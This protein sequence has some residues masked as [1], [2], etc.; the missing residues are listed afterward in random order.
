MKHVLIVG[1]NS[2]IGASF[3]KYAGERCSIQ[4][5]SAR[6]GK[7]RD[8]NFTG[9]DSILY[10]AGIAHAAQNK[11]MKQL[12]YHV[13]CD[14]AV[15]VAEHAKSAGVKQFIYLSSMSVYGNVGP[16]IIPETQP[17]AI[18]FYGGSKLAAEEK[19]QQL[20]LHVCIL[21]PPMV[22]GFGCKGNFPR[23]V[24]LSKSMLVFPKIKNRRSMIYIDNLCEFV[25]QA[26]M[27]NKSGIHFPQNAEYVNTTELVQII[28]RLHGKEIRATGLLNPMIA[29][30]KNCLS[31]MDKL[32]GD[33]VYEKTG[34]EANYNVISFEDGVKM[35][36]LGR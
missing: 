12:Y 5:V 33:L 1:E 4:T 30:L 9:I 24:K 32:F 19:L 35:A 22:Y 3:A 26:I 28:S 20:D 25:C 10:C 8:A 27:E 15:K 7:W 2:Y 36:V 23:L 31:P 16:V 21:R 34:D 18:D 11:E 17:T 14:L 29:I 13:N 6:D